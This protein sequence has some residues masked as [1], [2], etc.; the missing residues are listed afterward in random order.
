MIYE[1]TINGKDHR[2]DLSRAAE[3]GWQCKLDGRE[4]RV[5]ASLTRPGVLSLLVDNQSYEIKRE[6]IAGE[7]NLWVGSARYRV[8]IRDPRSMRGRG[9]GSSAGAGPRKLL[10]SM[11]GKVI[12]VLAQEHSQV[13][14]GQGILVVE[15]MKMQNEVKSPKAGKVQK[16]V[17]SPGTT[18]NAGDLLAIVE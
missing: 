15:A 9:S 16:I 8:E 10:A 1:V 7:T 4:V 17:A 18:V 2:L 5:D 6:Q 13:E 14:A 3:G 12:R 11:P